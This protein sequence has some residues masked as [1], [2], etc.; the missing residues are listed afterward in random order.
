VKGEFRN[1]LVPVDFSQASHNAL[2]LAGDIACIHNA[3]LHVLHVYHDVSSIISLRSFELKEDIVERELR[4]TVE[5]RF[6]ALLESLPLSVPVTHEARK[7]DVSEEILACAKE[8][9]IDLLVI[10]TNARSGLEHLF[11]GSVA[12]KIVRSAQC[13]VLTCRAGSST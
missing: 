1:I 3:S 2:G 12:Q 7:G 13:P 11:I 8:R 6:T 5:K 10:A 9:D 4:N